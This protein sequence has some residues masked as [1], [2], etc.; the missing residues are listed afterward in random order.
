MGIEELYAE[1]NRNP[2]NAMS[3]A[4]N[5][6]LHQLPDELFALPEEFRVIGAKWIQYAQDDCDNNDIA[7]AIWACIAE[8]RSLLTQKYR[9]A[10]NVATLSRW[11][12]NGDG[13]LMYE[14]FLLEHEKEKADAA[15]D[16]ERQNNKEEEDAE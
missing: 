13:Y 2:R 8:T 6:P 14:H 5:K 16:A 1:S 3:D 11:G 12:Y 9:E 15:T 10:T 7:V 4:E